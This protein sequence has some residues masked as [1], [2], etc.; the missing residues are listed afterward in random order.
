MRRAPDFRADAG[1]DG[2][3]RGRSATSSMP[4]TRRRAV[5]GSLF[6]FIGSFSIIAGI[7]LLVNVFVMLAEERKS[8]LG[9]LHAVGLHPPP[10]RR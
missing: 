3:R 9:M 7:L 6:L 1:R 2:D 4:P 10:P 5:M 8:Q